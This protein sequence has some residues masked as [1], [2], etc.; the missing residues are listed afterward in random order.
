VIILINNNKNLG[1]V[2]FLYVSDLLTSLISWRHWS[3]YVIYLPTSLFS[4][5]H[6][7]PNV[8]EALIYFRH[9]SP[10][11]IVL[12]TSLYSLRRWS[13]CTQVFDLHRPSTLLRPWALAYPGE[14]S[15]AI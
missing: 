6:W 13:T 5:R 1:K 4:R 2:V 10:H 14:D 8:I 3:S 7:S 12:L 11:V 15:V 9:W